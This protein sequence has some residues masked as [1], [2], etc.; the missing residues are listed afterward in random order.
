M[1]VALVDHPPPSWPI[2]MVALCWLAMATLGILCAALR[3]QQVVIDPR[4]VLARP[5]ETINGRRA[6]EVEL[7]LVLE[8]SSPPPQLSPPPPG[9]PLRGLALAGTHGGDNGRL[10]PTM[11]ADLVT[12]PSSSSSSSPRSGEIRGQRSPT[13]SVVVSLPPS[14]ASSPPT[15]VAIDDYL[16]DSLVGRGDEGGAT[17]TAHVL[18]RLPEWYLTSPWAVEVATRRLVREASGDA[19]R[20]GLAVAAAMFDQA[21]L[22]YWDGAPRADLRLQRALFAASWAADHDSRAPFVAEDLIREAAAAQVS[23]C[24]VLAV[25]MVSEV[26]AEARVKARD[27]ALVLASIAPPSLPTSPFAAGGLTASS[28]RRQRGSDERR[29]REEAIYSEVAARRAFKARL[30]VS[31]LWAVAA[32]STPVIDVSRLA[33]TA[34][35]ARV[36]VASADSAY[37]DLLLRFPPRPAVVRAYGLFLS[38][39]AQDLD[40]AED[41]RL[42]MVALSG[43]VAGQT[44]PV[45]Y[46]RTPDHVVR[47]R[48]GAFVAEAAESRRPPGV[49]GL[50]LG[51]AMLLIGVALA[52]AITAIHVHSAVASLQCVGLAGA[53]SADVV[54]LAAEARA[55]EMAA[56]PDP[57]RY[58]AGSFGP[59]AGVTDLQ[60]SLVAGWGLLEQRLAWL[61]RNATVLRGDPDPWSEVT[62]V[63]T[64]P[65]QGEASVVN[66]T[67]LGAAFGNALLDVGTIASGE[68]AADLNGTKRS[69]L[70]FAVGTGAASIVGGSDGVVADLSGI[71]VD[72][73]SACS[74]AGSARLTTPRLVLLILGLVIAVLGCLVLVVSWRLGARAAAREWSQVAALVASLPRDRLLAGVGRLGG[75]GSDAK[76]P[77]PLSSAIP[78]GGLLSAGSS[79]FASFADF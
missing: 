74:E 72:F 63:V 31:A 21:S 60:R 33:S 6:A 12:D 66:V 1:V 7:D 58:A 54:G 20:D 78:G 22:R 50:N 17:A 75:Q 18:A 23:V 29:E 10:S 56:V 34:R 79:R 2:G 27:Q 14:R 62:H 38:T 41:C 67:G 65:G 69:A 48:V 70:T 73:A 64:L 57:T 26:V 43:P 30:R 9:Q 25:D 39:V 35:A 45:P 53:A 55:I 49:C 3:L 47:D 40:A 15:V 68:L 77:A 51:C 28:R 24:Q 13:G 16:G 4:K 36:A 52:G 32:A 42:A 59:E 46:P 11:M 8:P 19:K 5:D 37:K 76:S 61:E 44:A 71:Y